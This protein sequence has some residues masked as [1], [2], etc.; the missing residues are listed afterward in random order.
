MIAWSEMPMKRTDRLGSGSS[1]IPMTPSSSSPIRSAR[2]ALVPVGRRRP[3]TGGAALAQVDGVQQAEVGVVDELVLLPN[4]PAQLP[5]CG[6][7]QRRLPLVL[8]ASVIHGSFRSSRVRGVRG[9]SACPPP[10]ADYLSAGPARQGESRRGRPE[11][12]GP[13][14]AM[15]GAHAAAPALQRSSPRPGQ[16]VLQPAH[17]GRGR[18]SGLRVLVEEHRQARRGRVRR[19]RCARGAG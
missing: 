12:V 14:H 9:R 1:G 19:R 10:D 7:A 18:S 6:R 3:A 17:V 16:P 13:V 11:P 4:L 15:S 5:R 2:I 8:V